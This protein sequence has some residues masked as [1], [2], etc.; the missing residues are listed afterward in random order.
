MKTWMKKLVDQFDMDWGGAHPNSEDGTAKK[1]NT[2][3]LTEDRATLLYIL[4]VYNKHLFEIQNH[5]VRKVR[6]KLDTFAKELVQANPEEAEKTMFRIRQFISSYRIDEY[7]YVQN[8]F[9]DFKRI[10]WDFADHLSEEAHA[11][12]SSQADINQSLEG[13]REAVESNSIEDLRAKSREFINFYLKHQTTK[14]DRRSKRM[15]SIKKNLTTVKKQLMEAN[16][17]AR[18]DHMTGA[19]NRRSYDEQVRRYLQLQDIDKEPMTL[20]ILDIDFFKK[21]NDN[22]GHDFGDFVLK[23]C[24]RLLQESFSREEDFIARLGGE[25]FGVI[26]PGCNVEAAT[27]MADEAM[28]RIRKEA[29][30]HE[31]QTIRF[32]VSMGI[33]QYSP[34]ESPDNWYKRADEALYESKQTGRNKYSLASKPGIKRVA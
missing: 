4:D 29:F 32:T 31:N 26:L 24:V 23:E 34:G 16:Q 30:V 18:R 25:E 9:D 3:V 20:I 27:K 13:L 17:T 10:I 8:T 33:A 2:P 22:Y 15:E 28:A 6:A 14:N 1:P 11:E 7:S 5:S 21:I 12:D 19:H